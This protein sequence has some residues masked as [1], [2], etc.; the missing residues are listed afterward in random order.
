MTEELGAGEK[1]DH[2]QALRRCPW[3]P[4]EKGLRWGRWEAAEQLED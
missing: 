1:G 2:L 3:L 4:V